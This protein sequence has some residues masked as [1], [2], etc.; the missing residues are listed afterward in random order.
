MVLYDINYNYN[1]DIFINWIVLGKLNPIFLLSLFISKYYIY[2]EFIRIHI[3]ESV[4]F[5]NK[6]S[7]QHLTCVNTK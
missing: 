1:S 6:K 5:S 7:L 4:L 3:K 2:T